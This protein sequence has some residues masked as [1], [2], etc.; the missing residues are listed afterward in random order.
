[1]NGAFDAPAYRATYRFRIGDRSVA[2]EQS[3][4]RLQVYRTLRELG[5]VTI[6]YLPQRPSINRIAGN[7]EPIADYL[8]A[9]FGAL[10]SAVGVG[11]YA[12]WP[13]LAS[14]SPRVHRQP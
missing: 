5:P 13:I 8:I 6:E 12:F 14:R 3:G 9:V 1:V 11:V 7:A 2:G 4:L 10:V